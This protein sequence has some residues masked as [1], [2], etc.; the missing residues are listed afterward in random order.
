MQPTFFN[1]VNAPPLPSKQ[2]PPNDSAM[3]DLARSPPPGYNMDF[4][5][6]RPTSTIKKLNTADDDDLDLG[7]PTVPDSYPD[8]F[9]AQNKPPANDGSASLDYDDLTKRFQ[10]LKNFK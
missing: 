8:N 10:N 2:Q 3:N 4:F 9:V 5:A 6:E 1:E 7:L